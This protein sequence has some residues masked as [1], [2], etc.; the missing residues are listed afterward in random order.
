MNHAAHHNSS[1]INYRW[2]KQ[3]GYIVC[4]V[5]I[6][7]LG[8]R[9]AVVILTAS[10][11][12]PTEGNSWS[13]AYEMG[14]IAASI[15]SGDGFGWPEYS[16]HPTGPT[17][18]MP[19]IYPFIIAA[20]FK[21]FGVYSDQAAIA[22]LALQT[23]IS[24]VTCFCLYRIGKQ[25]FNSQVGLLAAFFLAVYPP[26]IHF[27]VQ[28]IWSTTLFSCCLLLIIL[29]LMK[30]KTQMTASNGIW[31]GVLGGFTA[32]VD[33]IIVVSYPF[34]LLW[35]YVNS[36]R[37]RVT[38]FKVLAVM[39]V[40]FFLSIG[41]W[42][43]RNYIVFGQY[44][45]IKS[46]FG[47]EL[48]L[49]NNKYASGSFNAPQS[50]E[51]IRDLEKQSLKSSDEPFRNKLLLDKAVAFISEHPLQFLELTGSRFLHYWT[52]MMQSTRSTKLV[53]FAIY[54]SLLSV[55]IAGLLL[56]NPKVPE[57]Q[58]IWLFPLTLPLPYYFTV[59]G[60]VRYRFPVE[61]VLMIPA[62]YATYRLF[63]A[64]R[65]QLSCS[66]ATDGKQ[67]NMSRGSS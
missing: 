21:F 20:L 39:V 30:L 24:L 13:F 66:V 40:L 8:T 23:I 56:S 11:S 10:W 51:T 28:K 15:A 17:A 42:L 18:W 45:F 32:L 52:F 59:V 29:G 65:D 3:A 7:A 55:G 9:A 1:V 36:N 54:L 33:P 62:A 2:S 27:A 63:K 22:L 38:T 12:F 60:L 37:D 67:G 35:L 31:L 43:I 26:S 6:V 57:V 47:H 58:L 41:P 46:N 53:S 4:L 25:V 49:G 5:G 64:L 61:A 48:F 14:Q 16:D 50:R 44:V 19:P 34:V